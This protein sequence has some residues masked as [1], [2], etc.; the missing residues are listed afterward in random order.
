MFRKPRLGCTPALENNNFPIKKIRHEIAPR[1]YT[2][3]RCDKTD[4]CPTFTKKG[5]CHHCSAGQTSIIC[6]KCNVRL[7]L[8]AG[9]NCFQQFHYK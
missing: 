1:S 4:H 7:C 6:L 9:R 8:I 5:R 2:D 3:I